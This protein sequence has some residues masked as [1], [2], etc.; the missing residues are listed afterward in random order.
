MSRECAL[1]HLESSG[2]KIYEWAYCRRL[3][4]GRKEIRKIQGKLE[5]F[6]KREQQLKPPFR[7]IRSC[8]YIS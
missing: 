5:V 2:A 4:C 3:M 1:E 6:S 8:Q 7:Q